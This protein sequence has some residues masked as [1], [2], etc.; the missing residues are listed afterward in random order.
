[1]ETIFKPTNELPEPLEG[2]IRYD[3]GGVLETYHDGKWVQLR[4]VYI[5]EQDKQENDGV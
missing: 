2:S 5:T 1:M 4:N 3:I